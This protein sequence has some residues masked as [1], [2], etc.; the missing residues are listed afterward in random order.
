MI[1]TLNA[2]AWI[3]LVVIPIAGFCGTLAIWRYSKD[4]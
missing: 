1:D 3:I 4:D 2:L